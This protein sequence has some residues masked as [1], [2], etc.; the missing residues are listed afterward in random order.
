MSTFNR[1]TFAKRLH[2]LRTEHRITQRELA[3]A[4]GVTDMTISRYESGSV[5]PS[6]EIIY[7]ICDYFNIGLNRLLGETEFQSKDV[8]QFATWDFFSGALLPNETASEAFVQ[9]INISS[10][11]KEQ[12][13]RTLRD[14]FSFLIIQRE[15]QESNPLSPNTKDTP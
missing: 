2:D 6:I 12:E 9:V 1:D 13:L 10:A 14:F 5:E 11:L 8:P 15:K 7:R 3:K 4:L